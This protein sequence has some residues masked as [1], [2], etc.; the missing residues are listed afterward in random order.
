MGGRHTPANSATT[1]KKSND[2]VEGL[3]SAIGLAPSTI[4]RHLDILQRDRLVAFEEVRRRTGRPEYSFFLTEGGHEALPKGYDMLLGMLV[5]ELAGMT[6]EETTGRNGEQVLEFILRRLSDRVWHRYEDEVADADL[7]HRLST[8]MSVLRQEDFFPEAEVVDGVLQIKL[9]NC[10]FRAV[11]M[12][13]KAVC[14]FDGNLVSGMLDV[15]VSREACI[16]DGDPVCMYT[17]GLSAAEAESLSAT[18]SV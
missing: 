14:S 16:H 6:E 17:A 3:A 5:D 15:G 9:F 12:Q 11:A 18:A 10:P 4:R 1:E 8:L 13:N 2:T 7:E